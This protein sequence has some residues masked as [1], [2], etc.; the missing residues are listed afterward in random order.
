MT[1]QL[2]SGLAISR[3]WLLSLLALSAACA[4]SGGG[5]RGWSK[6]PPGFQP[7]CFP[8]AI[9]FEP[10]SATLM[11][12][13]KESIAAVNDRND[14]WISLAVAGAAAGGRRLDPRLA[15]S[16]AGAVLDQLGR[17]GRRRDRVDV[18]VKATFEADWS[19]STRI[20]RRRRPNMCKHL[21]D[22]PAR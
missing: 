13:T 19:T 20:P 22:D 18:R 6:A 15:E 14:L 1:A 9:T 4:S 12:E 17:L 2:T 7:F 8:L 5:S 16:R 21:L 3:A 10:G 11:P